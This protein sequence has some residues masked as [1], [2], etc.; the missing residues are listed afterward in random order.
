MPMGAHKQVFCK[1]KPHNVKWG[2][3][4]L[5]IKKLMGCFLI[6]VFMFATILSPASKA[7]AITKGMATLEVEY[8]Y[9]TWA[10][11]S[12]QS[13]G[14]VTVELTVTVLDKNED[15]DRFDADSAGNMTGYV[16]V[17]LPAGNNSI[18][19]YASSWH[20]D[21]YGHMMGTWQPPDDYYLN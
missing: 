16:H 12:T 4:T 13:Q 11:A 15:R 3:E 5:K 17:S 10:F 8:W 14:Y 6:L 2:D 21:P 19:T 18:I 7:Y 9:R 1:I 20:T